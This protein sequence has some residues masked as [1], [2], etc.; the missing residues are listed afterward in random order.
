MRHLYFAGDLGI[1]HYLFFREGEKVRLE[2]VER[3]L[4]PKPMYLLYRKGKLTAVLLKPFSDAEESGLVTFPLGE[5]GRILDAAEPVRNT[6]GVEG[7]HLTA[8]KDNIYVTNYTSGSV[9][10]TDGTLKIHE[11]HG[12]NPER[13]EAAHTHFVTASPDGK[14]L[15]VN[16]L[17]LDTIF[18]YDADL[19]E[20]GRVKAPEGAGPRH[21]VF[22]E[23]GK[24]V[25]CANELVNTVSVYDYDDGR[26]SYRYSVNTLSDRNH[27]SWAAAIRRQGDMIYVSNR[28][29]DSIAAFRWDGENLKLESVTP[30]GG[31]FPRDFDIFDDVMFVTNERPGT[32]TVFLVSGSNF[33]KIEE[34]LNIPGVLSV[35]SD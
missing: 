1:D 18:T 19:N 12:P 22:D 33:T 17:G 13:Q 32:V 8:F 34:E 5:D 31:S 15:L 6:K 2:F 7:C 24:T 23:S 20:I 16:D 3:K 26:L 10:S 29:E 27:G 30:V 28:G 25:F 21:L 35:V 14:Y 4:C 9:Y 11:G